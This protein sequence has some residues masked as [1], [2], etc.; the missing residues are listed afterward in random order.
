MDTNE[1]GPDTCTD[2]LMGP[3]GGSR[4]KPTI[5]RIEI[6]REGRTCYLKCNMLRGGIGKALGNVKC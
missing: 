2:R 3:K 4:T 1:T 6:K 5:E